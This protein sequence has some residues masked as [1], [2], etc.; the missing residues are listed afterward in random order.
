MH[1]IGTTKDLCICS[2]LQM[3][4]FFGRRGGLR[5]TMVNRSDENFT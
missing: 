5:M 2:N 3:R 4:G 1:F